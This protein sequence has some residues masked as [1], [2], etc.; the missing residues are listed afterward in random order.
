ME[1]GQVTIETLIIL[2]ASTL[3]LLVFIIFAWEQMLVAYNA[4]QNTMANAALTRIVDEIN[5]SYYLGAGTKKTFEVI[6]PDAVDLGKSTI[7]GRTL[8]LH[9]SG[10]DIITNAAVDVNGY[11]PE[12]TGRTTIELEVQSG[13]VQMRVNPE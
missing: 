10:N 12:I 9:I 4:Q 13:L 5:D 3:M 7:T 6:L 1:K 8:I 2:S 11:W